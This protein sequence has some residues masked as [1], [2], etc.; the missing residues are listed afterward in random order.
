MSETDWGAEGESAPKKKT[1]PTW[2]WFGG[3]GCL[4]LVILGVLA[5]GFAFSKA[6]EWGSVEKQW[7][8][9]VQALPCDERPP[10]LDFLFAVHIGMDVYIFKDAR[11]Y[12]AIFMIAKGKNADD[13]RKTQL[14]PEFKG[15]IPGIGTGGRENLEPAEVTVQGRVVKGV[16]FYQT[17]AGHHKEESTPES[18]AADRQGHSLVLDVT[19]AGHDGLVLLQLVRVAGEDPIR[20]EEVQAFLK[21]FHVGDKR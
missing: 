4:A 21:P 8:E 3:C 18:G 14:N 7:P 1:I 12:M 13:L 19:P 9:L 2:L 15:G 16:R 5:L 17:R 10:E 20:D 11:G 6:K